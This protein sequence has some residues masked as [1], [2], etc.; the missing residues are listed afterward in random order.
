MTIAEVEHTKDRILDWLSWVDANRSIVDLVSISKHGSVLMGRVSRRLT[1]GEFS[2]LR[3]IASHFTV[4]PIKLETD[5]GICLFTNP[6]DIVAKRKPIF[7]IRGAELPVEV[8][9]TFEDAWRVLSPLSH[10]S[11]NKELLMQCGIDIPRT[12]RHYKH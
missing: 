1:T 4:M 9:E 7:E 3:Q 5:F 2:Y 12:R 10:N 6:E 11:R 8:G